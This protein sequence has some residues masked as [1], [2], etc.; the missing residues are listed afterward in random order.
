MQPFPGVTKWRFPAQA[1]TGTK[2]VEGDG[3]V[4]DADEWHD[5]NSSDSHRKPKRF[6][7]V[8]LNDIHSWRDER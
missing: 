4:V 8:V 5:R 3:E 2:P 7:R 6:L 1:F